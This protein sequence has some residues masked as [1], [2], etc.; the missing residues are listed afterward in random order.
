MNRKN[1]ERKKNEGRVEVG[2]S[3][4]RVKKTSVMVDVIFARRSGLKRLIFF[5]LQSN[6]LIIVSY[7]KKQENEISKIETSIFLSYYFK[8]ILID[9]KF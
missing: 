7:R 8:H 5:S 9:L 3:V 6:I 4:D 2:Q 1:G